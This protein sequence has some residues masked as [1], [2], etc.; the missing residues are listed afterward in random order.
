MAKEGNNARWEHALRRLLVR[1]GGI[2]MRGRGGLAG[3]ALLTNIATE[4]VALESKVAG[5]FADLFESLA[6]TIADMEHEI[7]ALQRKVK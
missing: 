7:N 6:M 2:R 4:H 3:H 1:V 5:Q